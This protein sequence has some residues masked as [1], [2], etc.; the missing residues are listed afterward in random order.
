MMKDVDKQRA[1]AA[2]QALP[3]AQKKKDKSYGHQK[4]KVQKNKKNKITR[5]DHVF[6]GLTQ[7]LSRFFLILKW[8]S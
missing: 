2:L 7:L 6:A 4:K 1:G 5:F 8:V 3:K